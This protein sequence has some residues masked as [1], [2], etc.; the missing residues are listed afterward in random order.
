MLTVTMI[1]PDRVYRTGVIEPLPRNFQPVAA[2]QRVA[3][4]F[5][6]FVQPNVDSSLRHMTPEQQQAFMVQRSAQQSAQRSMPEAGTRAV[7]TSAQPS[8]PTTPN[9]T[10][11]QVKQPVVQ[12]AQPPVIARPIVPVTAKPP[13]RPLPVRAAPPQ[14]LMPKAG[15][16]IVTTPAFKPVAP[17]AQ[18]AAVAIAKT[19]TAQALALRATPK[20]GLQVQA[21][22]ARQ[23]A[24]IVKAGTPVQVRNALAARALPPASVQ[25]FMSK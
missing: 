23:A 4:S 25:R 8:I 11:P 6:R 3:Q 2:Y 17:A 15:T 9:V 20:A 5:V 14:V 24:A 1:R 19:S 18:P 16:Q 21:G 22:T 7:V 13:V 12:M 10:L